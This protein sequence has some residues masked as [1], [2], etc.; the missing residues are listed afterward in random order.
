MS[1]L[2]LNGQIINVF[3]TPESVDK[4]TGEVR[5]AKFRIQIM[6]QNE[7]Q[8]GQ[9]RIDLVNLTVDTP[10]TYKALQGQNVR[11]PVG[12]FV[13]GS[14]VQFYALKGAK[15]ERMAGAAGTPPGGPARQA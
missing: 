1:M 12:A 10:E 8:N 15:P 6:A 4:K 11:V 7:L 9:K 3:D 13:N 5:Q 14:S 2:T